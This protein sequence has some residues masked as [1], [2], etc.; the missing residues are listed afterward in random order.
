MR[1]KQISLRLTEEE[2]ERIHERMA[3]AH[4]ENRESFIRRMALE[5]CINMVD[6]AEIRQLNALLGQYADKLDRFI[7][8]F[9][10]TGQLPAKDI[11]AVRK[12]LD[13]IVKQVNKAEDKIFN[14]ML[15]RDY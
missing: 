11:Q 10:A 3:Q 6:M 8:H 15:P 7:S 1:N 5:G 13:N 4:T 2:Q 14:A 12:Q 9:E